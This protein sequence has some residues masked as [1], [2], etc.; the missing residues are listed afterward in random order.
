V[1]NDGRALGPGDD[2][3]RG[4]DGEGNRGGR[5]EPTQGGSTGLMYQQGGIED[6]HKKGALGASQNYHG[7]EFD[8]LRFFNPQIRNNDLLP[9]EVEVLVAHLLENF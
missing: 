4:D 8:K 3:D 9:E 2:R 1:D 6:L 7:I 5:R